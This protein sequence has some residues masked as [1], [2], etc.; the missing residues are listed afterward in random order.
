MSRLIKAKGNMY[1]WVT[2]MWEPFR[3][4]ACAHKCIYCYAHR[5]HERFKIKEGVNPVLDFPFPALRKDLTI[6][7]CHLSDLFSDSVSDFQIYEVLRQCHDYNNK[8][9]LQTKNPSRYYH[10]FEYLNP[11]NTILGTTIETDKF[12]SSVSLAP[13]GGL[14]ALEI[15]RVKENGFKTFITVEPILDFNLESFLE[16]F[17]YADPDF[18]NIGADSKKSELTEPNGDKIRDLIQGIQELGIE[19]RSKHNLERLLK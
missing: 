14:R 13:G 8:Y 11:E 19:I 2:H 17:E 9:V 7:V 1:P 15:K 18:I 4:Y 16:L 6:F 12:Q 10:F 5:M 3:P